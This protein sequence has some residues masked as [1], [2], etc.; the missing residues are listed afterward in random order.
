M[1][2]TSVLALVRQGGISLLAAVSLGWFVVHI[3]TV[4]RAERSAAEVSFRE[5]RQASHKAFTDALKDVAEACLGKT[6][7]ARRVSP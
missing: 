5:E 1:D 4:T 6:A 3:D 2:S 7:A